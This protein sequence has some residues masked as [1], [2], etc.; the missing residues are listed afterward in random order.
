LVTSFSVAQNV[1]SL[2][3]ILETSSSSIE[4][5]RAGVELCRTLAKRDPVLALDVG[6]KAMNV[7]DR[8]IVARHTPDTTFIQIKQNLLKTLASAYA[9]VGDLERS[10]QCLLDELAIVNDMRDSAMLGGVLTNIGVAYQNQGY[11]KEAL[12]YYRQSLGIT[13]RTGNTY[14]QAMSLGNIGTCIASLYPD[15]TM[16][17][18]KSALK[19]ADSPDMHD[20]EG[21]MGWMLNN[22]GVH[23]A[24][25]GQ[26]DSAFHYYFKSL[27]IRK[28]IDHRLGLSII[29]RQIANLYLSTGNLDSALKCVNVALKMS[30]DNG[31]VRSLED[32]YLT[33]SQIY[34]RMN[35]YQDAFYDYQQHIEIRDSLYNDNNTKEI[36][37]QTMRYEY[38]RKHLADSLNHLSEIS[39]HE[40]KVRRQKLERN[41]FMGG[42][43]LVG[44]FAA[45]FFLQ[46]NRIGKEKNRSEELLLN[47][48]PAEVAQELKEKGQTEAQLIDSVTVLFTDFKGFTVLTE[49]L[50]PK[51]L[52]NDLNTCFSEFDHIT[53]KYGIEKIKTIGDSYMAAGG[54]PKPSSTHAADVINAAMEMRDV[55]K[56]IKA[57]RLELG[58]PYFEIRIGVHTG[59]VV[60][61]IVGVKK[62]QYDIWGDTV[63]TASRM[64]SSGEVGKI[65]IS[66]ASY[67]LL[68]YDPQ[69]VFENRGKIKAKGKGKIE[70]YFVSEA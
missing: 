18:Y 19:V 16:Y 32:G 51:E 13:R 5:G 41:G 67:E 2:K 4:Q 69:F 26:V 47:I 52:V 54:L 12:S 1:D 48:L 23:F 25:E 27:A 64:E 50:S 10:L 63:N 68:K 6:E 20:R 15:S 70:M 65:N 31:F 61:G 56:A 62:F 60:A 36:V 42:F 28:S 22:I 3:I 29:N 55:V 40:Q 35:R 21:F 49:K 37:Q 33:R 34:Q 46:R 58:L 14:S 45:V 24:R 66:Q 43:V 7:I 8:A 11:P 53:A 38:G 59:P 39:I 44:I 9:A 57:K 30:M 17:Y